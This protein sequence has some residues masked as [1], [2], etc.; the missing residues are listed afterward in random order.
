MIYNEDH[1][2]LNN[3]IFVNKRN[4]HHRIPSIYKKKNKKYK[5]KKKKKNQKKRKKLKKYDKELTN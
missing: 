5:K 3:P 1:G 2:L 4:L